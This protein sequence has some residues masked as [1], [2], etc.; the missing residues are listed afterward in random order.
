MEKKYCHKYVTVFDGKGKICYPINMYKEVL[1]RAGLTEEEARVY[2]ILLEKGPQGAGELLK[3]VK[4][5]KR[6]LLYKTLDRLAERDLVLQKDVRGKQQF[7]PQSPESLALLA[8]ERAEEAKKT[9]TAFDAML[10]EL[11]AKHALS[12]ERPVIRF[13]EGKEGLREIY[14]DHLT[15][16]AKDLYFIRT[17]RAQE[18]RTLFGTWFGNYLKRQGKIGIRVHALTVD[19]EDTNHDPAIDKVRG[20]LRTWVRPE[21]YTAPIQIDSYG[22]KVAILS[23]GKEV[24]GILI[25]SEPLAR[26]IREVLIL[27]KHGADGRPV[28]HNHPPVRTDLHKDRLK[29]LGR[30]SGK[31]S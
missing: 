12:T 1:I 18:Y 20:V 4:P 7:I 21:D 22:N 28:T 2:E 11:K 14:E 24:F 13:F 8:K 27:A 30:S 31:K 16:G 10:P 19:D 15:S 3:H 26:A 29:A 17:A 9:V 5:M 25:E 23:F 6:G